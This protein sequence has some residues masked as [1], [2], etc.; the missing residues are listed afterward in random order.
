MAISATIF[1]TELHIADMDR[2][3]YATHSLTIARHPSET[4]ERMMVRIAAFALNAHERLEFCKGLSTEHEAALW[5]KD[6][7]DHIEHWIDV[8]LP[9]V[10]RIRKAHNQSD[11]VTVYAYGERAAPVWWDS[12]KNKLTRFEN[13]EVVCLPPQS[14]TA[15]CDLVERSMQLQANIQD[16]E[17]WLSSGETSVVIAPERLLSIDP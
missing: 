9:D 4:D 3:Y 17:M 10:D 11:R 8:G 2:N 1:K 7:T 15:L 16:G 13:L 5:R 12:V 6:L 14:C